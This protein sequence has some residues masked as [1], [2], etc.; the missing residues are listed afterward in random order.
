MPAGRCS[1][2]KEP[3]RNEICLAEWDEPFEDPVTAQPWTF[4]QI[5]QGLI[6]NFLDRE[7]RM[8]LAAQRRGADSRRRSSFAE[9]RAGAHRPVASAGHG[10]QRAEQ[11]CADEHAR[12]RRCFASALSAVGAGGKQPVATFAALQN[13]KEIFEGALGHASPTTWQRRAR[14]ALTKSIASRHKWPTR[15]VRPPSIHIVYEHF[16]LT[17]GP[18]P[19]SSRWSCSGR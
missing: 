2:S 13:A 17:V 12:L 14:R 8:A 16:R 10:V 7:S 18:F 11:R 9:S 4:R 15:L 3:V 6:D 1:K 5:V 19:A